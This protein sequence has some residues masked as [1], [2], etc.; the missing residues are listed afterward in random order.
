[1][2][3]L[4]KLTI[5]N[6]KGIKSLDINFDGKNAEILGTNGT[7][8]TTI[9]DA[10]L[11]LLTDKDSQGQSNFEIKTVDPKTKETI[12]KLNHEVE[13]VF[14][15]NG[16]TVSLKKIYKENWVK[17]R[18]SNNESFSGHTT[19]YFVNDVPTNKKEYEGFIS[20]NIGSLDKVQILSNLRYFNEDLD[21]K[22][23]RKILADISGVESFE[24]YMDGIDVQSGN[25]DTSLLK[26]DLED[27]TPEDYQKQLKAQM[28]GINDE[29]K[30]IPARIVT[31]KHLCHPY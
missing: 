5:R 16:K 20:A 24:D 10:Y 7:G 31:G 26:E 23:R 8:K 21:W 4:L 12:E 30:E 22:K 18:G 1:M 28:K 3:K 13:A 2:I 14:Q 17:K 19:D 11:W 29:I 25:I 27:K 6:F 15:V 9:L